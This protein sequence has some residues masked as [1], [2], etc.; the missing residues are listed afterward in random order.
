MVANLL[1][2]ANP[3]MVRLTKL[4]LLAPVVNVTLLFTVALVNEV[5]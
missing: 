2:L 5:L 4:P 1:V 3:A